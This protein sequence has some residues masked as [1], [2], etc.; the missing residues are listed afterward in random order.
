MLH[1]QNFSV[2]NESDGF[3]LFVEGYS[4]DPTLVNPGES[5]IEWH[6]GMKFTTY[7][8][9]NDLHTD[10]TNCAITY[11]VCMPINYTLIDFI[12]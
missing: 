4:F 8:N 10:G 6:N 3:R 2:G 7:D 11:Q 1:L 12:S 5:L 9:D